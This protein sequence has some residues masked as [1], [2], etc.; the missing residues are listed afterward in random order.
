M[1]VLAMAAVKGI[2]FARGSP[3]NRSNWAKNRQCSNRQRER[4]DTQPTS[5]EDNERFFELQSAVV[6]ILTTVANALYLAAHDGC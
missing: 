6:S 2:L 4:T 1:V 5:N 3:P